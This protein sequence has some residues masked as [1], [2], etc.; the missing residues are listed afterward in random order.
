MI[1]GGATCAAFSTVV[2][3]LGVNNLVSV[4]AN[5]TDTCTL[6]SLP[7][8]DGCI[9]RGL[10]VSDTGITAA[11]FAV[12]AYLLSPVIASIFALCYFASPVFAAGIFGVTSGA[13]TVHR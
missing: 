7:F 9:L 4:G 1:V 10:V 12:S 3:K 2:A 8:A 6:E 11:I 13:T 5:T